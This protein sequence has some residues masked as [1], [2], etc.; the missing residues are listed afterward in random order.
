MREPPKKAMA[1]GGILRWK[2]GRN[3]PDVHACLFEY[4]EYPI[5]MRLN[6]GT[7]M[8]EVVRFQGS[9]GILEMKEFGLSYSPQTGKDATP[10]YYVL[11]HPSAMRQAYIK[12]WHEE[13]DP[14]PG[15]EPIPETTSFK[16]HDYDDMKPHLFNFFEAV[17]SHR[18]VVQD[19]VFGHHAALA[20]HMA[21]E[22]YFRQSA[23]TWDEASKSIRG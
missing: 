15:Q 2:D 13:N 7:E 19:A 12:K 3:M 22:S 23:V 8:E 5:Y 6:L 11:G 1:L 21:N 18:P 20:C 4:R 9:K 16:G 17:R 10:S 14:K